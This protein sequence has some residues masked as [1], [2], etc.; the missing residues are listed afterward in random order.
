MPWPSIWPFTSSS[1]KKPKDEKSFLEDLPKGRDWN[2]TLTAF[3]WEHYT[4]PSVV[5]PSLALTVTTLFMVHLYKKYLRRIPSSEYIRPGFFRR[6]SLFG[7]VTRVGDGDNFR[8]FHTPGGRLAGWGWTWRRVPSDKKVL[9]TRTIH[10]RLA[11]IDAPELAHFGRPSQPYGKEALEF[12]TSYIL[13][14]RVRAFIYRRDQYE[15]VVGT[16]FVRKWGIKHDVGLEML[17][18]GL[19]TVYEAKYGSEFGEFEQKY[20]DA[21]ADAKARKVG[22]WA[23]PGIMGKLVG[24]GSEK[25]LESPRAYK[26]RMGDLEKE[27]GMPVGIKAEKPSR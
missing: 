8:L 13:H 12:L 26:K 2:H 5:I 9:S 22:M 11:G 23:T 1:A 14:R 4:Q 16:V 24:G 6:R 21:E 27:K 3:D 25:P 17:K 20:R 15:R 10:V 18:R 19:A 7:T